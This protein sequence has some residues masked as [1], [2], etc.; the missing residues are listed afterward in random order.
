MAN[1]ATDVQSVNES[2]ADVAI[3]NDWQII[4]FNEPVRTLFTEHN[5][6][7][8]EN[9]L[10]ISLRGSLRNFS[11]LPGTSKVTDLPYAIDACYAKKSA[12][13]TLSK[14]EVGS[15]EI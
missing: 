10:E 1:L 15:I 8:K 4:R 13:G 2:D 5:G 7:A 12:S 9:N 11:V 6:D 3:S 14:W